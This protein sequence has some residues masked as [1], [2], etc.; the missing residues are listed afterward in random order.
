MAGPEE[1]I[2]L[3]Q[4][5]VAVVETKANAAHSR[6]DKMEA[7]LRDDIRDLKSEIKQDMKKMESN[8]EDVVNFINRSKGMF[9]VIVL[10]SGFIAWIIQK[11]I[12][13]IIK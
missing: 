10:I 5:R 13:S 12:S 7:F 4:E 2:T 11:I 3:L 9:A 8:L 1:K 6:I